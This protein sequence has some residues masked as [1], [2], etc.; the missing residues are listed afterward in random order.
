ME[1]IDLLD[2]PGAP[3]SFGPDIRHRT[4][5]FL[6]EL[7]IRLHPVMRHPGNV[8]RLRDTLAAGHELYYSQ[9]VGRFCF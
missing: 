8:R 7:L 3:E 9:L 2:L 5:R 4:D 6:I 1:D